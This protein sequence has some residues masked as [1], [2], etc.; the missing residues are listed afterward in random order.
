MQPIKI[1]R[2]VVFGR[3]DIYI[4]IVIFALAAFVCLLGLAH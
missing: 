4:W 1:E 2:I 3:C